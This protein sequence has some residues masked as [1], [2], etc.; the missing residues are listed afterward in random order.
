MSAHCVDSRLAVTKAAGLALATLLT[1]C[2][3]EGDAGQLGS[4]GPAVRVESECVT[5]MVLAAGETESAAIGNLERSTI[6]IHAGERAILSKVSTVAEPFAGDLW[7]AAREAD[8]RATPTVIEVI[9]ATESSNH[10][11][12]LDNDCRLV[13]VEGQT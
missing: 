13:L 12:K 11:A 6:S 7:V 5:Q 1:A 8:G 10:E 4:G 9:G 3:G 2:V